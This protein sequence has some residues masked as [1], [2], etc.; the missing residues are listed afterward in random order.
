MILHSLAE[1]Y[2]RKIAAEPGS[3]PPRGFERKEIPFLLIVDE[4]GGVVDFFDTR[5][6]K[7]KK[8]V[9]KE[10]VAPASIARGSEIAAN[11]LWDTVEYALGVA[12][13]DGDAEKVAARHAAFVEKVKEIDKRI[14]KPLPGMRAVLRFLRNPDLA[15]IE[16]SDSDAWLEARKNNSNLTFALDA[17]GAPQVVFELDEV[18]EEVARAARQAQGEEGVCLISG[19]R[20]SIGRLHPP[21]QGVRNAKSTGAKLVSF[22][23]EPFRS[24]GK[25]Q[26]AN[27]PIAADLIFDYTAAL[28]HLLRRDSRQKIQV[29]DATTI[30]WAHEKHALEEGL[31]AVF[32][33][34]DDERAQAVKS[35]F[36]SARVGGGGFESDLTPFYVLGLSPNQSRVSVRFWSESTVAGVADNVRRHFADIEIERPPNAPPHPSMFSLLRSLAVLQKSE[37][38]PPNLAGEMM[39]SILS[40]GGYPRAALLCAVNRCRAEREVGYYRA[41]LLRGYINRRLRGRSQPQPEIPKMLDENN[42]SPG[43]CLGRLFAALES[44]QNRANPSA[45]ATIRDRFYGA[46]ST[47]PAT[48]F[49]NLLK[50]SRHHL[51]KVDEKNEIFFDGMLS[52][53]IGNLSAAPLPPRLDMESQGLFALGYYHQRQFFFRKRGG[54]SVAADS[55]TGDQQ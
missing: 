40:G 50:L 32:D 20:R 22:K 6:L 29:G 47:S 13:E 41:A 52:R 10:Y 36:E 48:I 16:K 18:R 38:I 12:R 46:A 49:P 54:D 27:A 14:S 45:K 39:R 34:P 37:N 26:G 2:A 17:P 5:E 43:Y 15:A 21:F 24:Y 11:S 35:V 55:Q 25:E 33:A 4:E 42:Q 53:I 9:G 51:G 28:R 8:K 44:L 30:F 23:L 19:A 7:G 31:A 1:Y 3:L